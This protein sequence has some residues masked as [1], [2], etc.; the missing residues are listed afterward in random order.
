MVNRQLDLTSDSAERMDDFVDRTWLLGT[1]KIAL[2]VKLFFFFSF[3]MPM[4]SLPF[5]LLARSRAQRALRAVDAAV[6]T[7]RR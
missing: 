1:A 4:I 7:R 2:G 3:L 6:R 5:L